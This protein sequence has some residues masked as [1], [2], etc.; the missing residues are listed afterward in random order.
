MGRSKSTN[1]MATASENADIAVLKEQMG[2]VTKTLEEIKN[3]VKS[4][5]NTFSNLPEIYVTRK[6]FDLSKSN[7][8]L[9]TILT[10]VFV[11]AIS[12]LIEYFFLTAIGHK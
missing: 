7:N 5:V 4:V 9:K 11:A 1:S 3:D 12:G 10:A 6:E 8:L 2:A